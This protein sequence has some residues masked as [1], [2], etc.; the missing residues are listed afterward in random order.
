MKTTVFTHKGM[1]GILSSENAEGL[2]AKPAG[3]NLGCICD[4]SMV[5]IQKE[6]LD[7]LNNIPKGRDGLGEIDV[8]QAGD[9]VIFG[10]LGGYMKAFK[11]N[12]I[13]TSRDYKPNLLKATDGVVTPKE[14]IEYV[15]SI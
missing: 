8:F 5:E 3:G 7:L 15:D 9:K 12:E 13:K 14:F 11:P 10:W 4:A 2:I 1:I 6:A